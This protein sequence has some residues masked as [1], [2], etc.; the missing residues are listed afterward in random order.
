MK[1]INAISLICLLAL[2]GYAKGGAIYTDESLF[3]GDVVELLGFESFEDNAVNNDAD[4]ITNQVV[5][6]DFSV[7]TPGNQLNVRSLD[8]NGSHAVD[9][10]NFLNYVAFW[11]SGWVDVTFS[12]DDAIT[13]FGV[14]ITDAQDGGTDIPDTH[15]ALAI[16]NN[17][18]MLSYTNFSTGV[19]A[20]ANEQ[21]VGIIDN[22]GFTD[23]TIQIN[24]D[25]NDGFG[26]DAVHYSSVPEP[27]TL[28]LLSFSLLGL[29]VCRSRYLRRELPI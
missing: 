9:G 12:F 10:D 18:G 7:N 25:V 29:G 11:E 27:G 21:F 28:L 26:F 1:S 3:L 13:S 24:T 19:L 14:W 5:T 4:I 20:D 17:G 23:V 22:V 2:S 16:K 8:D 6:P 15:P